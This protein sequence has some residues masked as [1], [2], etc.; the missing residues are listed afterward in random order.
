MLVMVM[1]L[2]SE[3]AVEWGFWGTENKSE[4]WGMKVKWSFS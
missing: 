2:E 1:C 3:F 4:T